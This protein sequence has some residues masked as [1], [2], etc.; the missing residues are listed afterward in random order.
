ME[1]EA[2]AAAGLAG[3]AAALELHAQTLGRVREDLQLL[4]RPGPPYVGEGEI[5]ESGEGRAW[6]QRVVS[7]EGLGGESRESGSGE[8]DKGPGRRRGVVR[9]QTRQPDD[10]SVTLESA[11][12]RSQGSVSPSRK[13]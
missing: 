5:K 6:E 9:G 4:D 10:E 2:T 12:V 3:E 8:A 11:S 13:S 1:T 7:K